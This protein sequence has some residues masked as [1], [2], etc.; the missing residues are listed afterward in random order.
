MIRLAALPLLLAACST[1]TEV[2]LT[3]DTTAIAASRATA[4]TLEVN[5]SDGESYHTEVAVHQPLGD[6][7]RLVYRAGA[8][9][10]NLHFE[11]YLHDHARAL[12]GCGAVDARLQAG[13]AATRTVRLTAT[14]PDCLTPP[15]DLDASASDD[16]GP[17][18]GPGD[19]ATGDGAVLASSCATPGAGWIL[20]DDFEGPLNTRWN[21]GDSTHGSVVTDGVH[22][23]G[24]ASAMHLHT[25]AEPSS[26]P[27]YWVARVFT[28]FSQ[29]KAYV[30]AWVFLG[31]P[32]SNRANNQFLQMVRGDFT[33]LTIGNAN[34]TVQVSGSPTGQPPA[35]KSSTSKS[36]T[37][38][39]WTC[40]EWLVSTGASGEIR[41]SLDGTDLPELHLTGFNLPGGFS[42]LTFEQGVEPGGGPYDVFIDD[43]VVSTQPI[44]CN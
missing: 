14:F 25:E 10:G 26:T 41:V 32:T 20:C 3:L 15:P 4:E 13:A 36:F 43:V 21:T 38:G 37:L 2:D 17:D 5:V 16:G 27:D 31:P 18:A 23:H 1:A 35:A 19:G 12:V 6:S 9:S 28:A 34:A 33:A 40:L 39:A 24:G 42:Y 11:L 22:A 8:R 7:E 44:G 29:P 30:R